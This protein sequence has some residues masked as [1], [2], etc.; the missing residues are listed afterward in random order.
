MSS[1]KVRL[2]NHLRPFVVNSPIWDRRRQAQ[3]SQDIRSWELA[4]YPVPP[5][6]AV[7]QQILSAYRAAFD[8]KT[9]VETGTYQG[10]MVYAMKGCFQRIISIELDQT[11]QQ[12][13]VR[14][15]SAHH[16][17]E[18]RQGDSGQEL[19]NL[20][21]SLDMPCL[22]WLDGHYSSGITAKGDLG[23]PIMGELSSIFR[24]SV[25]KHVILI[26]DARCFDGTNDY[27]TIDKLR[28]FVAQ[29]APNTEFSVKSDIIR[30]CPAGS[31]SPEI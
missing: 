23:T 31:H 13:A 16:H 28:E 22:F 9:L 1:F 12:R 20:L 14:R 18:I 8:L 21:K 3:A 25:K 6:H 11:L 24:H 4:G 17:I 7:K 30:I 10:D 2:K 5:P 27:P 26:D 15:F 19:T 29:N